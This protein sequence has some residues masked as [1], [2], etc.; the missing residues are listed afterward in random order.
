MAA[1]LFFGGLILG[2][3]VLVGIA[4]N[5]LKFIGVISIGITAMA[6]IS[7]AAIA[8]VVTAIFLSALYQLFGPDNAGWAICLSL[9]IGLAVWL[10]LARAV[11]REVLNFFSSKKN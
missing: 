3:L 4:I 1:L 10:S 8:A 11:A 5:L 7:S 9:I 6:L 2:V